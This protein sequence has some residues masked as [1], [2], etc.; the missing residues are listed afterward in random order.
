[1]YEGT[2]EY[3]PIQADNSTLQPNAPRLAI[4]IENQNEEQRKVAPGSLVSSEWQAWEPEHK[5]FTLD[6]QV[7]TRDTVRLLLYPA[8]KVTVDGK[9]YDPE[10]QENTGRMML[11]LPAGHHE[12]AIEYARTRDRTWGQLISVVGLL[13]AIGL[14]IVGRRQTQEQRA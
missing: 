8:W 11:E 9:P 3:T 10:A 12:V 13:A 6:S 14:W 7:P 1:V 4:Q 5:R 2:D